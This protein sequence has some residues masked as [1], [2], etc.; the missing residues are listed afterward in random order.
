MNK[1]CLI[2]LAI[3]AV[4]GLGCGLSPR[5]RLWYHPQRTLDQAKQDIERCY[6]EAFL[7]E[8]GGCYSPGFAHDTRQPLMY[9]E[10]SARQCMKQAGYNRVSDD[11]LD[12]AAKKHTGVVHGVTYFIAGG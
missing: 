11:E 12:P 9:V 4:G 10:I 2:T 3:A 5:A 7:A 6:D 1:I 8:Q